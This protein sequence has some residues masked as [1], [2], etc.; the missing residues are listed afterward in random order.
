MKSTLLCAAALAAVAT[1]AVARDNS[2]Y[3]GLEVGVIQAK[4]SDVEIEDEGVL[5]VDHK[6]GVDGDMI[7]GYDFGMFRLEAEL[8]YKRNHHDTYGFEGEE[9]DAEGRTSTYSGM[10]NG[11]ID[12]GNERDVAFYAGGGIGYAQVI[13]DLEL[14][15]DEAVKLKHRG[16]A[17]QL[18]AGLRKKLD[19][20][21]DVGLKYRYFDAGDV[22]DDFDGVA[23]DSEYKSHSLLFSLI[24]NFNVEPDAYVP[25]PMALPPPPPP[26]APPPPATKTC[27]DGSVVLD[28]DPCPVPPPPPPPPPPLPER[29]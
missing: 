26:M 13:H 21:F 11:M 19:R 17:W 6:L 10:L 20:H 18:I 4:D 15:E 23:L 8:G 12:V 28:I 25:P 3:F 14:D 5:T 24:H 2:A 1:P 22:N 29:G 16:M 7:A 27:P 9:I